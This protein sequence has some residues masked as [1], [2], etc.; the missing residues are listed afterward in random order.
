MICR[1]REGKIDGCVKCSR[2]RP[3]TKNSTKGFPKSRIGF[4]CVQV[5]QKSELFTV[6]SR[7][8]ETASIFVCEMIFGRLLPL[9]AP[10]ILCPGA[11]SL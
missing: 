7:S 4:V 8:S 9:F 3:K 5:I 1:T 10:D 2:R 6:I 11:V